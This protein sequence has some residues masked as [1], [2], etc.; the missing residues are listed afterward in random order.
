MTLWMKTMVFRR[1]EVD[2]GIRSS[3]RVK[4]S[5]NS[6]TMHVNQDL[7]RALLATLCQEVEMSK[8]A[9]RV[10]QITESIP[11]AA[12]YAI[13]F[14]VML[15]ATPSKQMMAG[16]ATASPRSPFASHFLVHSH[17][18]KTY[19]SRIQQGVVAVLEMR[20]V[21]G[22][23]V[24]VAYFDRENAQL[25]LSAILDSSATSSPD[26]DTVSSQLPLLKGPVGAIVEGVREQESQRVV[27]NDS[28]RVEI[29]SSSTRTLDM[30][31]TPPPLV[32][33]SAPTPTIPPTAVTVISSLASNMALSSSSSQGPLTLSPPS[34]SSLRLPTGLTFAILDDNALVRANLLR[35]VVQHLHADRKTSFATG[36]TLE[37]A[38]FFPHD[39]V[40]REVDVAIFDENLDY[41]PSPT[42][43]QVPSRMTG[44][45]LVRVARQRGFTGCA[46]L[47]SANGDL[48]MD[49]DKAA[50]DGFVEKTSKR[51]EFIEGIARIW[52]RFVAKKAG[53]L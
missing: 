28:P 13:Q 32:I 25:P 1:I 4:P 18:A 3:R 46:I 20:L 5:L 52:V 12:E 34:P 15:P 39:I 6:I 33:L 43:P 14:E 50:F 42:N 44:S 53:Q 19:V 27:P 40:A 31:S 23:P 9:L 49:Y 7:L 16:S 37:E 41:E 51:H 36:Q 35:L 2:D 8:C 24:V 22:R 47:H 29:V 45:E 38:I 48:S 17:S 26:I 21:P 10:S 11:P 30:A